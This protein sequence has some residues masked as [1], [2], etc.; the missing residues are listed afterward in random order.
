MTRPGGKRGPAM[1]VTSTAATAVGRGSAVLSDCGTYRYKLRRSWDTGKPVC[2]W[3]MLNPSTADADR[4]DPTIA[5]CQGFSRSWGYGGLIVVNLY[6]LRA[7]DPHQLRRHPDPVGDANDGHIHT[8]V[9]GTDTVVCAWGT[10]P[11]AA[12][13]AHAVAGILR[14]A[15]PRPARVRCLGVTASGAPRHPLYTPGATGLIPFGE[16]AR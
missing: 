15:I 9:L 2:L 12:R 11:F 8:A 6:A 4:D 16:A 1:T 5:R 3:V 14:S 13:R 10:H 7:T